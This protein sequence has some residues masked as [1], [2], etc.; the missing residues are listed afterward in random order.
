M[1]ASELPGKAIFVKL[2]EYK[3]IL[4]LVDELKNKLDLARTTLDKIKG[5]KAEEDTE[6]ELWQN[7]IKEIESKIGYIDKTLMEPDT[8][9]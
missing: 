8:G 7:S 4:E 2:N 1:D 6:L 5:L 9:M 3:D